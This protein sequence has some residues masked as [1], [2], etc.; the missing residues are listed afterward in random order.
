MQDWCELFVGN[1]LAAR[2]LAET[3]ERRGVRAFVDDRVGPIVSRTNDR[4][5]FSVVLVPP[6]RSERAQGILREWEDTNRRDVHALT[7]RLLRI[8]TFSFVPPLL[9]VLGRWVDPAEV[10]ELNEGWLLGL[11]LVSL[12]VIAQVEH[13]RKRE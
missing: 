8:L 1:D 6:E 11:W 5:R 4:S 13:R 3:L 10:P 9:W 2:D 7:G 12:V